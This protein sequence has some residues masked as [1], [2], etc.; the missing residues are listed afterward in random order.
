[1]GGDRPRVNK[2]KNVNKKMLTKK[3]LTKNVNIKM[4]HWFHGPQT[5]NPNTT[6][7]NLP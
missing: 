2:Q 3:L 4:M 7:V 1:M 5:A 6:K